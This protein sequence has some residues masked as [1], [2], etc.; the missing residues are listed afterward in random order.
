[1]SL[2]S[3]HYV[4]ASFKVASLY[5]NTRTETVMPLFV[6]LTHGALLQFS[7]WLKQPLL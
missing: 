4:T 1:M 7:P 2:I 5:V 3:L 6:C